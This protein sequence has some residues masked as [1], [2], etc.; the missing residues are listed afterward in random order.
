MN[1]RFPSMFPVKHNAL[2]TSMSQGPGP[3]PRSGPA[4]EGEAQT[5]VWDCKGAHR[6]R[7][8]LFRHRGCAAGGAVWWRTEPLRTQEPKGTVLALN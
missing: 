2:V 5:G 3:V 4:D 7:S 6:D 8:A 1:V